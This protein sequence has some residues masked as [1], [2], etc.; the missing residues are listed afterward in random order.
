MVP[1]D[2]RGAAPLEGVHRDETPGLV[3]ALCHLLVQGPHLIEDL[4]GM[5]AY[6]GKVQ[7]G[8]P[9]KISAGTL[10]TFANAIFMDGV[11]A[12]AD[13]RHAGRRGL[14]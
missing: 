13:H 12:S 11:R 9:L 8:D 10:N 7:P 2:P 5:V 6:R 3:E 14:C 4:E 1:A